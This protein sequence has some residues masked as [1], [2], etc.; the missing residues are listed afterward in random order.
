MP[1]VFLTDRYGALYYQFI[2]NE[3][4]ELPGRAEILS[5]L[6]FIQSQCPECSI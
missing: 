1:S 6:S 2:A 3:M 5:W 4:T